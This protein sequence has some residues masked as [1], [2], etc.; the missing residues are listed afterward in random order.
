MMGLS[1]WHILILVAV[2]L[3]VFGRPGKISNLM[4]DV[5]KGVKAFKTGMKEEPAAEGP[6][7]DVAPKVIAADAAKPASQPEHDPA[8]H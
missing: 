3:L 7:P 2:L 4:G 1:F 6:H 8:Q 5:A